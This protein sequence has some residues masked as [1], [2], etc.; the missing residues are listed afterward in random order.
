MRK[1]F[2]SQALIFLLLVVFTSCQN[3]EPTQSDKPAEHQV[4]KICDKECLKGF[5]D[6][7]MDAM[8]AKVPSEAFFTKECIFTENGVRLPL[9][10]EGL[11]ASMVGKG[12]Y[13][14]YVPDVETQQIGFFG[15]AREE[16]QNEGDKPSP[17]AIAL[18]LKISEG[19]ISEV[20]QLVIRPESNLLNPGA[21][22][23]PSSAEL[24]EKMGEEL[25]NPHP[26]YLEIIPENERPT[27]EEMIKTANYYFSGMQKNDGKGVDGTGTYPFT[28][29]CDRYENGGRSTNVPLAKGQEMPDPLKETVYTSHWGCK[30][31]FESGLIYFVTRIRDR[32]F[33][34]VDR[35]HGIVF[36]F[37]F[38]DHS[39]GDSRKFTTPDGRKAIEGPS[40][41][42][43][44][45]IAEL[46]KVEKGKIRRIEA[47]LQRAP[48][49]MNSGWSSYEDGMSDKI[50]IIK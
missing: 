42:W 50:Q 12:T 30:Q 38:F 43:T 26:I 23:G 15:T 7:Y 33:V 11:W 28:D 49:G 36:S 18:R 45:Q 31:Q 25:G 8:L 29:D 17:V 19:L 44:W 47:I 3:Q 41:P 16:A 35:E 5:V 2:L 22:R 32:R 39:A 20:E 40:E 14:F 37:C 48:Y 34:A 9:G 1:R 4:H 24:I 21:E 46:F 27:R 6:K 13:K 10:E